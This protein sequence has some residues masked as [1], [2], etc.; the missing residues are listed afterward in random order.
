[1]IKQSA[2]MENRPTEVNDVCIELSIFERLLLLD[3]EI[4]QRFPK[5]YDGGFEKLGLI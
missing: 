5:E 4:K 2:S 3:K 1:M